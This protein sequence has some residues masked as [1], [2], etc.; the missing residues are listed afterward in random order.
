MRADLDVGGE[1]QESEGSGVDTD[2]EP[3]NLDPAAERI[4]ALDG[5]RLR[6]DPAGRLP[7][8]FKEILGNPRKSFGLDQG[9]VAA[10]LREAG[11]RD[12]L[13]KR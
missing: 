10:L 12:S 8:W 13:Q 1:P 3:E 2:G 9:E 6:I 5:A 11:R 4:A 7:A